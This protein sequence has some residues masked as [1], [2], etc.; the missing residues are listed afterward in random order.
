MPALRSASCCSA[1]ILALLATRAHAQEPPPVPMEVP[2]APVVQVAANS[3]KALSERNVKVD[4][5]VTLKGV[6]PVVKTLSMVAADGRSA[7]GRARVEVGVSTRGSFN[8][9]PVDIN[10]DA[11]PS[12]LPSGRISL[13]LKMNFA[14]VY[15]PDGTGDAGPSF[16]SGNTEIHAVLFE[17]GKS[18]TIAQASDG[19][20][21]REYTVDVKATILK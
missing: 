15:M 5:T 6:K 14:T 10:V 20:S 7:M 19:E 18:L 4:L 1:A 12:I 9:R 11:I 16:G 17:S 21:G 13:R 8:Y 2:V 3:N